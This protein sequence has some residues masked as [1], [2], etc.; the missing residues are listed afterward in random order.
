MWTGHSTRR[1]SVQRDSDGTGQGL[2]NARKVRGARVI[3]SSFVPM[4][5]H[6]ANVKLC[7]SWRGG[8]PLPR[9]RHS[10][11]TGDRTGLERGGVGWDKTGQDRGRTEQNR[12]GEKRNRTDRK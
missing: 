4:Q 3:F 1:D 7:Q 11:A 12:V 10:L 5:R 2:G 9:P 8:C 6:R